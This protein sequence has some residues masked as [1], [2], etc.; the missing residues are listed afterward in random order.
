M[1]WLLSA[2]VWA[3][4]SVPAI[5]ALYLLRRRATRHE[6]PSLLLWQRTESAREASKP[7]QK[8]R[9]Q[10]LLILQLLLAA[11]LSLALLRPALPG[12]TRGEA[13]LIFDLSASMQA[14]REGRTRLEQAVEDAVSLVDGMKE[15][16]A[17]TIITAG[18]TI[19]QVLSRSTDKQKIRAAL[20]GLRAEN[21]T[22]DLDA[23]LSLAKAM[24]QDLQSLFIVVYSDTYTT[25]DHG[26][27]V[28]TAGM[29]VD[30]RSILSL[31]CS[32]RE[33]GLSAFAR[34]ANYGA[35]ADISM[36]CY[37]DGTLMDVRALSLAEGQEASVQ[38][39]VPRDA[40]LVWVAL[41]TPDALEAD[42]IR[43]WAAQ[44]R[45]ER[46]V[47]LV[48]RGNIFLEKALALRQDTLVFKATA[49][50]AGGMEGYDLVILDGESPASLP[51]AGSLLALAPN[52]EVWGITPGIASDSPGKLRAESNQLARELTRNLPLSGMAL[53]AY[54]PLT[55]GQSALIMGNDTL[56]ATA[57]L[58][59]RRAAVIGFDLHDSN[60][61]M[62]ADFPI[63]MQNL[64]DYL[65]PEA[66]GAVD[67]MF[68]GQPV[69]IAPDEQAVERQVITPGGRAAPVEGTVFTDTGEIGV[70]ALREARADGSLRIT[71]FTL[72]MAP[73]EADV[74]HVAAPAISDRREQAGRQGAG[75]ELTVFLLLAALL[76]SMAEWEVSRR[77][78]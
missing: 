13:A 2:G 12:V 10:W 30:N 53:R 44:Q 27:E 48:T 9:K 20:K 5:I 49:A 36:E 37:A 31:R 19:G 38:F 63:L 61:P 56:L 32:P 40:R 6:V 50:D 68:C 59:G 65:L 26:V 29:G 64:M 75:R 34:I 11:L 7:F 21:G 74:R 8:L 3:F 25:G 77:G 14:S 42:N 46:R 72:H 71:P 60:L 69:N 35:A 55:G 47:L 67:A 78:A 18:S 73:S 66:V 54:T 52:R 16:D 23:A 58:D 4:V 22:A 41:T 33:D 43:F 70:Y 51:A 39:S 17:V 57:E 28:R 45:R 24:Q 1:E 15:G 76:L 62:L